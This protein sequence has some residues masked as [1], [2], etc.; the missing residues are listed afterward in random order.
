M[1]NFQLFENFKEAARQCNIEVKSNESYYSIRLENK[2]YIFCWTPLNK[3]RGVIDDIE[4]KNYDQALNRLKDNFS[5]FHLEIGGNDVND[6][7]IVCE[8]FIAEQWNKDLTVNQIISIIE[9]M[10]DDNKL[11]QKL[12]WSRLTYGVLE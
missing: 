9:T 4:D 1:L 3:L 6:M 2:R 8:A 7:N 5:D 12:M 10:K 11:Q